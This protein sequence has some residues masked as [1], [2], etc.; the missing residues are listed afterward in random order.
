MTSDEVYKF[1]KDTLDVLLSLQEVQQES[2][3]T[4]TGQMFSLEGTVKEFMRQNKEEHASLRKE[5][6]E[7]YDKFSYLEESVRTAKNMGKFIKYLAALI[8][9]LGAIWIGI[10]E[11]IRYMAK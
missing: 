11:F 6:K 8:L 4:L 3:K 7:R 9:A 5:I 1:K 2:I 10:K